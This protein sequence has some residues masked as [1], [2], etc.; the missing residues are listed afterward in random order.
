MIN[1]NREK[2]DWLANIN[3][4]ETVIDDQFFLIRGICI[5]EILLYLNE[6]VKSIRCLSLEP[7]PLFTP[8]S[9]CLC[10][11]VSWFIN[12]PKRF[13]IKDVFQGSGLSAGIR[14]KGIGI[15]Q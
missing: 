4:I 9:M 6:R 12:H 13:I 5:I 1:K 11:T 2:Q 15:R 7:Q 3:Q 10:K 14:Q 8:A